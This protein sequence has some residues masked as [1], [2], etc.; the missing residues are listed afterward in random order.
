MGRG[1][2]L[3]LKE[4]FQVGRAGLATFL[5]A[6]LKGGRAGPHR[7]DTTANTRGLAM[8]RRKNLTAS[9]AY[10]FIFPFSLSKISPKD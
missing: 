8:V 9:M 6:A 1:A 2:L 3:K 4:S 5:L 10:D 7:G